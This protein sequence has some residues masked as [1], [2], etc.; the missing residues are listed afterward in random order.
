YIGQHLDDAA[1]WTCEPA[2]REAVALPRNDVLAAILCQQSEALVPEKP[3]NPLRNVERLLGGALPIDR[4]THAG[5]ECFAGC[6]ATAL[7]VAATERAAARSGS[8]RGN[9]RNECQ[10]GRPV[11]DGLAGAEVFRLHAP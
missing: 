1:V 6:R 8:W 11:A 10:R 4:S 5:D 2:D 3:R 7:P 9:S